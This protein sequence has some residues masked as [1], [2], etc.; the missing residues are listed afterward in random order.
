MRTKS[1][2]EKGDRKR[3]G[4]KEKESYG[5]EERGRQKDPKGLSGFVLPP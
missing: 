5:R 4:G 3:E 2:D 1:G